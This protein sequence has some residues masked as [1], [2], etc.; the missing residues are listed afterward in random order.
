MS[1]VTEDTA[2]VLDVESLGAAAAARGEPD[3]VAER[4]RRA[5]ARFNELPVPGPKD[6][7]WRRVPWARLA[8]EKA[9][10]RRCPPGKDAA[11]PPLVFEQ[12]EKV[13]D[14]SA[15]R[16]F[17]GSLRR[18][19]VD[20]KADARRWLS[21]EVYPAG[22]DGHSASRHVAGAGGKF[23][24]L[25]QALWDDG[26]ALLLKEGARAAEPFVFRLRPGVGG[27]A[28][29]HNLVVLEAGAEATLIE[30]LGPEPT[31]KAAAGGLENRP[32]NGN[33]GDDAKS[34]AAGAAFVC[35]QTEIV[36]GAG[37]RLNHFQVL[38]PGA[39]W[40]WMGTQRAV[41]GRDSRL[42]FVGAWLGGTAV[43][44]FW[45]AILAEPGAEARA[46]G[47]VYGSEAQ[48]LHFDT[49][50]QHRAPRC[51]GDLLFKQLL[52]DRARTVFTGMIEVTE[53]ARKTDS[54]L[55]CRT[56]I[57]SDEA[58]AEV[59]P[60][61]EIRTDDV[62]CSHGATTGEPD[63][64]AVFYLCS[65]GLDKRAAQRM[66]ADGFMEEVLQRFG[67]EEKEPAGAVRRAFQ[68]KRAGNGTGTG[69]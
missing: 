51:T 23:H 53:E 29:P 24:A 17:F 58:H 43:K 28:F 33:A 45:E 9:V 48:E 14:G 34:N 13:G 60:K 54:Y 62:K 56:L 5:A 39:K 68:A 20:R 10:R 57:M 25:N 32:G 31:A 69:S 1:E 40:A 38:L 66:M 41:L 18:A 59:T 15:G 27:D 6:E 67:D 19:L 7:L 30:L 42:D 37:A 46:A 44:S 21:T 64:E 63:P 4:R 8:W 47:L 11:T 3:F 61:L 26:A 50:L 55:Q 35:S 22:D 2:L 12:G 16:V 36:L 52:E 65:R 49:L